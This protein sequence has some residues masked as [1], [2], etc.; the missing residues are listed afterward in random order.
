MKIVTAGVFA[1]VVAT[2]LVRVQLSAEGRTCEEL[3]KL[4]LPDTTI[5]SATSVPAGPFTP[6]GAAAAPLNMWPFEGPQ[7]HLPAFCRIVATTKPAVQF[8]VWLP[9]QNWNGKFQGV[10]NGGT[11]GV[12]S[13]AAMAGA[14]NR[15][16]ATA[17]T[18]TGHV[19]KQGFDSTWALGRPD[20]VADFGYRGLH[21]TTVNAKEVTRAFYA[22]PPEHSYYVGCSKGGQQGLMEAQRYPEDYD[23]LIA[24]DPANNWTRFS[25][26]VT[27][28]T[29]SPL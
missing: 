6:P 10:G 16:Y 28:G 13:Y 1:T 25:R 22:K 12:I 11:A 3:A 15:G 8:E 7:S 23:G 17:S 20:L 18:D 9:L 19:N 27:S 29:R 2:M 4:T 5:R 24:G 21:V 14:L 26:V